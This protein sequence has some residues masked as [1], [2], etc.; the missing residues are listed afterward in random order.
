MGN[1]HARGKEHDIRHK[2]KFSIIEPGDLL[3]VHEIVQFSS[4]SF[5]TKL[6]KVKHP[7]HQTCM[8]RL[9]AIPNFFTS[10][11]C[12]DMIK[13]CNDFKNL[14]DEYPKEY[15]NA[16]R[17]LITDKEF[18]KL[19]FERL[20]ETIDLDA[21]GKLITPY[22]LDSRGEWKACGINEMMRLSKY[23][24]GEYFKI[25]TDGQFRRSEHE[26]SI[27]TLLIYLNQD[28]KGGETRF[29]NDPTKTDSDFE[30]YSLLHTLKPS[31]GQLALFNQ[32]FY[33]EGCPVTKGTKYILR[34]EIMY[35]RVDSLS[36]P[37][38]VKFEQSE[39]YQKIGQL[40]KESER[41]EKNGDVY[42][43]SESYLAGQQMLVDSGKTFEYLLNRHYF[44]PEG[45][46]ENIEQNNLTIL[47]EEIIFIVFSFLKES[48]ICSIVLP[49]NRYLNQLARSPI[50]WKSVYQKYW[51]GTTFRKL[52]ESDIPID[53]YHH[54]RVRNFTEHSF[55][56]ICIDFT[57]ELATYGL[58]N[59]ETPNTVEPYVG[60]NS[61]VQ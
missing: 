36:I 16:S 42:A 56:A 44:I 2:T 28:F 10:E 19:I 4:R 14:E 38:D 50:I 17:E 58:F 48:E 31:L 59:V 51:D 3:P 45:L 55:K 60:R 24:P 29:Y 32:D 47:P 21:I 37:R 9:M 26:R 41:L 34:T 1:K 5:E 52:C 43:A 33:H 54:V 30:E 12:N 49:L 7:I 46:V 6:S 22:G 40:F 8:N 13:R 25:H 53:W 61:G 23:E 35:L 11:E 18:A 20:K 27:Y 39:A 57:S 15:R